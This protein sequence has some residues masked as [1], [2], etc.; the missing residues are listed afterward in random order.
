[1]QRDLLRFVV[2]NSMV[3]VALFN[4]GKKHILIDFG[5]YV[6]AIV[7]T[8]GGGTAKGEHFLHSSPLE[9]DIT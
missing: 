7:A 9:E 1:M 2:V 8:I 4:V 5:L 6:A 3:F